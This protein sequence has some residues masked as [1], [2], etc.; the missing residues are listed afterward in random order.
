MIKEIKW[1]EALSDLCNYTEL[2]KENDLAHP[3]LNRGVLE[4]DSIIARLRVG[5]E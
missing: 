2:H 1:M 5:S 4:W 3:C